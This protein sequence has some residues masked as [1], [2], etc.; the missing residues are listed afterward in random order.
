MKVLAINGSPHVKGNT[1]IALGAVMEELEKEGINTELITVGNRTIKGCV[2][3]GRCTSEKDCK[4]S[5]NDDVNVWIQKMVE[6]D[7]ILIGSPVYYAGING[8]LKA[9]LDRA[10][11]VA[12]AGGRKMRHKVG[13]AVVAVRRAGGVPAVD[14]LNKYFAISEMLMPTS[15][16]WNM[17]YGWT[18]GEAEKDDEGLQTMRVLGRN[19]AWLLKVLDCAKGQIQPPAAEQKILTN[20]IR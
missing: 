9:F 12:G 13:A 15:N 19:M 4:C 6:A 2:A 18:P 20:F 5:I 17:A 14:Q 1:S 3:C 10:F 7:G 8:T 16:Y 11:Y